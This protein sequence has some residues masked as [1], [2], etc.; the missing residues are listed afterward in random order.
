METLKSRH[1]MTWRVGLGAAAIVA[2]AAFATGPQPLDL[3]QFAHGLQV[4]LRAVA[5]GDDRPPVARAAEAAAA[6]NR[7]QPAFAAKAR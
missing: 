7:P 4:S 2:L 3:Q 1:A 5:D 6:A